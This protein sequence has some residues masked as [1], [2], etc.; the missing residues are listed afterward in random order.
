MI[1]IKGRNKDV[2]GICHRADVLG[3]FY[4]AVLSS[5]MQSASRTTQAA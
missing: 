1:E 5:P 3:G 4:E 2:R